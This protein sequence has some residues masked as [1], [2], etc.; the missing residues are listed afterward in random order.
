MNTKYFAVATLSL[1]L[2]LPLGLSTQKAHAAQ[3]AG[4]GQYQDRQDRND[5]MDRQDRQW[6]QAPNEYREA[7]R[8]GF[9]DGIEAARHDYQGR[10]H[11]DADDHDRFKHP[12]VEREMRNEYRDG[13]KHGYSEAMHHMKDMR[14]EYRH[15]R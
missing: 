12:P 13:F 1:S 4:V 9:Q 6:D 15:D 11:K 3:P 8:M 5:R 10:R 14:D 7:Q 2:A